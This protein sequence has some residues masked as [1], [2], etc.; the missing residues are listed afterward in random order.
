MTRTAP[1]YTLRW[2][3]QVSLLNNRLGPPTPAP[4]SAVSSASSTSINMFKNLYTS[5]YGSDNNHCF[6]SWHTN[7]DKN[8]ENNNN[9]SCN[10]SYIM[11]IKNCNQY[12]SLSN[13]LNEAADE[14]IGLLSL[15]AGNKFSCLF[16]VL[17]VYNFLAVE[18]FTY[19]PRF[20]FYW[21]KWVSFR[22][23]WT[24][25]SN[26]KIRQSDLIVS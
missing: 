19:S 3:S 2:S 7:N 12:K 13:R 23:E 20:A 16:I 9:F 10:S 24:F 1:L 4:N 26:R 5:L 6:N 14:T 22:Y 17:W 25:S 11:S 18:L 15:I 8:T 21:A